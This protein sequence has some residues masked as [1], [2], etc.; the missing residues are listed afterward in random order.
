VQ[1]NLI[2]LV[3]NNF[4]FNVDLLDIPNLSNYI[5]GKNVL[6][7]V[8]K[9][10]PLQNVNPIFQLVKHLDQNSNLKILNCF[11]KGNTLGALQNLDIVKGLNEFIREFDSSKKN[12][13]FTVGSNPVNNSIYSHK[14]KEALIDSDFVVSLDLF[15]NET[16]ELSDII[17]PTTTFGEKEGTFTNLEMRR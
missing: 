10:S 11:S 2:A 16:T 4:E 6:A 13:V 5:D 3:T 1:T 17:L 12:I 15:K 7:I 9:A 8:G 14:I